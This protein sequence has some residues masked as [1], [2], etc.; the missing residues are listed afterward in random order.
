[1]VRS[2]R[3]RFLSSTVPLAHTPRMVSLRLLFL[4]AFSAA[5]LAAPEAFEVGPAQRDQLP[6][7]KEAD[8]IIG[9]FI[10]R[11]DKVEAVISGSLPLRRANMS[12]FYGATGI[13]PG[14]LYDLTLRGANN[15]QI[16]IFSPA[17]QQGAVSWVRVGQDGK[18]GEAVL[19]TA[20]TAPNNGGLA[21]HHQYRL[22]DGWQGVLVTTT[23]RNETAAAITVPAADKWTVFKRTGKAHD[24]TWAE[25]IDP[26]DR[27]GY[28][29]GITEAPAGFAQEKPLQ[30][31]PGAEVKFTRFL[32]VA[33]SA[34]EALG[35]VAAQRG[36]VA[37]LSG[38]VKDAQ[39]AAAPSAQI[40]VLMPGPK[41]TI[42][43][44]A[45]PDA[46]GA[47]ALQLPAG[48]YE[49]S[50]E[51][52]GRESVTRTETLKAEEKK[53]MAVEL[54]AA[55]AVQFD[56]RD[57]AGQSLPV[58][59]AIPRARRHR[60]AEPRPGKSR[61]RLRRPV[62]FG[63]GPIPRGARAGQVSRG[64]HARHR[65]LASGAGGYGGARQ[66]FRFRG[67]AETARRHGRLGQRGLPQSLHAERRQHL[68][69]GR[70]HHQPRRR[71]HRVCADHGA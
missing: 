49:L 12:T 68:R 44:F 16:T 67:H 18:S 53:S 1:M 60:A 17:A 9:D 21:R 40:A 43:G 15:D 23:L 63:D 35:I 30:V 19:E 48:T 38:T 29:Y 20:V 71:A 6:R 3:I 32:A 51:D 70:P 8:G 61:A 4:L 5:A 10:L 62:P 28:A 52:Q 64:G 69:H 50:F 2:A 57:E 45:Y 26:A 56:I 33:K 27:A 42:A 24:I 46:Q 59:G 41:V 47:F 54:G 58:Q 31:A 39:G 22:R 66:D 36:P 25:A 11:N 14:C 55:S 7:G 13:T 65:V 34:A 37:T